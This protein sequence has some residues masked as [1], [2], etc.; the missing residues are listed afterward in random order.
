MTT[1]AIGCC[2]EEDWLGLEPSIVVRSSFA[3]D[4]KDVRSVGHQRL[5]LERLGTCNYS[6]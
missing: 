3:L 4:F 6:F 2:G 1:D 5:Q